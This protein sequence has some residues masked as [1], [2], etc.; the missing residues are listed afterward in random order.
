M[1]PIDTRAHVTDEFNT[2]NELR[3]W[4]MYNGQIWFYIYNHYYFMYCIKW[5]KNDKE[6]WHIDYDTLDNLYVQGKEDVSC[7]A[8]F[9]ELVSM[10]LFNNHSM[11][12]L[13][14]QI[15]FYDRLE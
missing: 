14:F 3:E 7:C 15:V 9:E 5:N 13:F 10:P 4:M 1:K 12:E 2:I 11:K 8:S 6:Q